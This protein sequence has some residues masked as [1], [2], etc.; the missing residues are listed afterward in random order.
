MR[1]ERKALCI[2]LFC[3]FSI[4]WARE[5][6]CKFLCIFFWIINSDSLSLPFSLLFAFSILNLYQDML[7]MCDNIIVQTPIIFQ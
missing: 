1:A 6:L 5:F 4:N 7:Q 3:L 2:E